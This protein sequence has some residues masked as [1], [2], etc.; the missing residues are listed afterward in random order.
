M[1]HS[2]SPAKSHISSSDYGEKEEVKVK[3]QGELY[4]KG[5]GRIGGEVSDAVSE[6]GQ[7]QAFPN[8]IGDDT[9]PKQL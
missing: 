9:D 4:W 1:A 3:V 6:P 8:P 2:L 5:V 7:G